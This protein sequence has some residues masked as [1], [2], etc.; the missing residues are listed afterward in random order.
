[1]IPAAELQLI[2]IDFIDRFGAAKEGKRLTDKWQ[3]EIKDGE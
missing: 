3:K 1:M 2:D